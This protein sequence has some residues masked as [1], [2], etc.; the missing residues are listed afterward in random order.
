MP[1]PPLLSSATMTM[2]SSSLPIAA[3]TDHSFFSHSKASTSGSS[4]VVTT[5]VV[6][7]PCPL[8]LRPGAPTIKV[9]AHDASPAPASRDLDVSS[10]R[11]SEDAL[12]RK[13]AKK[14]R[15]SPPQ[16]APRVRRTRAAARAAS[17]PTPSGSSRGNSLAPS[18]TSPE[19][20]SSPSTR[21]T[22]V[23]SVGHPPQPPREC[24]IDASGKPGPG[25]VSSEDVVR[26][27]M[28]RYTRCESSFF[29]S[30]CSRM[31]RVTGRVRCSVPLSG[32]SDLVPTF[33]ACFV[34]CYFSRL[35]QSGRPGRPF[36]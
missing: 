22:S 12:V 9:T 7:V 1:R 27:L 18:Y 8:D 13:H 29:L 20:G 32:S 26:D 15:V 6:A 25:F 5:R 24:W 19:R 30:H 33:P 17:S 23:S 14:R 21:A 3:S 31:R 10:K 16:E 11:K 35:S 4:L 28:K 36:V 34:S 2:S